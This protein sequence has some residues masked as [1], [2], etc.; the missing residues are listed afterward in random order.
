MTLLNI[1]TAA[2]AIG[3]TIWTCVLIRKLW[4]ER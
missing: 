2:A 1:L 4:T 3:F